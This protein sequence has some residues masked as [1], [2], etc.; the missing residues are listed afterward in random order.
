[1][2]IKKQDDLEFPH[3]GDVFDVD[4]NPVTGSE[5]G[6]KRPALIVSN[7][8]NNKLAETVTVLPF[9][10]S[11]MKKVYPFEV[12]ILKGTAGLTQDSRVKADQIRT[13][14]KMR[15]KTYRGSLPA[16]ILLQVETALKVHLNM[17]T[18]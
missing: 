9:T 16:D 12:S 10:S 6:K 14:D 5:I 4:F 17:K 13:V 18:P 7:N 11:P 8:I 15:L 3:F 2:V 1:M